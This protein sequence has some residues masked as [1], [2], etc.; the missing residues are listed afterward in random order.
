MDLNN[1]DRIY[2]QMSPVQM[3]AFEHLLNKANRGLI[4]SSKESLL[5]FF[6]KMQRNG[7]RDSKGRQIYNIVGYVTSSFNIYSA[8]QELAEEK[9]AEIGIRYEGNQVDPFQIEERSIN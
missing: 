1:E 4:K 6:D 5:K 8:Q 9:L 3:Q 2:R 7:W